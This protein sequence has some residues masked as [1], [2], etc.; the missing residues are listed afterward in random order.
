[1]LLNQYLNNELGTVEK[2][3]E[4][5]NP[6]CGSGQIC[7]PNKDSYI[8]CRDCEAKTCIECDALWHPEQSCE[9]RRAA[10]NSREDENAKGQEF[11]DTNC[12]RCPKCTLPG[13]K[14]GG[15]DHITC[16]YHCL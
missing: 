16:K 11:V 13:I 3:Q 1:M 14:D 6:E 5:R 15:C 10:T 7:H 8:M 9:E 2:F 4:C 12:K